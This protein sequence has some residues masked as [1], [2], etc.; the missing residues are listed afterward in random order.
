MKENLFKVSNTAKESGRKTM[1]MFKQIDIAESI[2]TIKRMAMENSFGNLVIYIKDIT[3]MM[4]E[5]DM[6]I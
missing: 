2:R 6:E 3:L 5:M 4:K 1:K